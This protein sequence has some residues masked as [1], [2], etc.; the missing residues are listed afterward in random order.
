MNYP[1]DRIC[2]TVT[3]EQIMEYIDC[4]LL[5]RNPIDEVKTI[6]I[7]EMDKIQN[8]I[9]EREQTILDLEEVKNSL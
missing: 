4:I 5:R 3:E 1:F 2:T 9:Y 8:E 6:L 7:H